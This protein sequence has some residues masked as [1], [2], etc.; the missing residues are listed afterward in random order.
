LKESTDTNEWKIVSRKRCNKSNVTRNTT[1]AITLH[2][3]FTILSLSN[4]PTINPNDKQHAK[5]QVTKLAEAVAGHKQECQQQ[6]DPR[7]HVRNTLKRLQESKELFLN[8]SITQ[9]EDERTT[10]AKEDTSNAKRAAIHAAHKFN[11]IDIGLIQQG[12][13]IVNNI[14]SPFK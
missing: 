7:R 9:A 4:N 12:Q 10:M 14:G 3:A 5:V 6:Q 8:G 2:N 1:N 13:N 11:T